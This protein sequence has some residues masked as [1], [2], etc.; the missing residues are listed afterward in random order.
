MGDNYFKNKILELNIIIIE[1]KT[2][3]EEPKTEFD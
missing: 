2:S 3:L 1:R